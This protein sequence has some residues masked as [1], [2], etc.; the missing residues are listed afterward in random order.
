MESLELIFLILLS[1]YFSATEIAFVVSNKIKI[2]LRARKNQFLYKNIFHFV[3][4]PQDFFSTILISNNI[5][6]ITF[7]SI[8]TLLLYN[9]FKFDEITI[10]LIS[11]FLILF[12]GELIPKYFAREIA[13]SF[14]KFSILPL[15]VI[16]LLLFPIVRIISSFST[17]ITKS[18]NLNEENIISLFDKEDM[19]SLIHEGMNSGNLHRKDSD[20]LIR[21]L[22]LGDKKAYESMIPRTD[23]SA[24]D[25]DSPIDELR[26]LFIDSGFSKIPVYKDSIDNIVGFVH[27]Y[28]LFK[29]PD[30][31]KSILREIIFI[32]STKKLNELLK[33]FL[34]KRITIVILVDEFGGTSGL[35][36]L[37]DILEEM[38]GEIRDEYDTDELICKKIDDNNYIFSG[39][40]S[41]NKL[42]DEFEIFLPEGDYETL[43]GLITTKVG[44]IPVKNSVIDFENYRFLILKSDNKKID[45][46][47]LSKL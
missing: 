33:I 21:A 42:Q 17:I 4:N 18:S 13:D 23:I 1:G 9:Y 29:N 25:I 24:I 27:V 43:S 10:L 19:H 44:E 41:I 34:E 38:I 47:K 26:K 40:V 5:V 28:D 11:T 3:N 39:K 35:I 31:I 12:F 46:V 37:E 32:P 2:E 7:S 14:M 22:E 6:N 16:Y 45:L 20:Y 30:S 36:T 15:R 8:S